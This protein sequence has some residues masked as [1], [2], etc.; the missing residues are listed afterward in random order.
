MTPLFQSNPILTRRLTMYAVAGGAILAACPP[1]AAEPIRFAADYQLSL[2]NT[3]DTWLT[4]ELDL[5]GDGTSDFEMYVGQELSSPLTYSAAIIG[6]ASFGVAV[7]GP[8][9]VAFP[10]AFA[11]GDSIGPSHTDWNGI[12]GDLRKATSTGLSGNWPNDLTQTRYEGVRFAIGTDV[13]YGW[14]AASAEV[15][16][17]SSALR[18]T[19]WGYETLA[20]TAITAGEG[21]LVPEPSSLALFALGAAGIAAVMRRRRRRV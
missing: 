2:P 1:A 6:L 10:V 12:V 20:D 8:G 21:E 9:L 16:D 15:T 19:G 14:I 11:A 13:H 17:T 4:R 5:D 7:D 3:P 18:V